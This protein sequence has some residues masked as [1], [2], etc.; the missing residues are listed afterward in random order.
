MKTKGKVSALLPL[1]VFLIVYAGTSIIAKDFY[2]VS[3][4]VPFLISAIV[5]LSMNKKEN[6]KI[7]F[8]IFVR[9]QEIPMLY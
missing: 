8:K 4:I 9:E 3:V 6:L 5:A 2:A 1:A 7:R